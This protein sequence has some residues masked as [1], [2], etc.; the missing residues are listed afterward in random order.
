M[1]SWMLIVWI[2]EIPVLVCCSDTSQCIFKPQW[3]R[4]N[5]GNVVIAAFVPLFNYF[6]INKTI[7]FNVEKKYQAMFKVKNY[8]CTL[9]VIF[10]TEEI[11]RNPELL[12]NISLGFD[13]YNVQRSEWNILKEAFIWLTGM[14]INIPNYA[15]RRKNKAVAILTGTSWAISAR[16]GRLLSLYKYPQLSFG[17]F[18]SILS[19]QDQFSA[20]YQTASKDTSLSFGIVS[21]M[22]H[23]SWTWVGL[24]L[25]DNHKGTQILSDLRAEMYRNKVC[26]AF[27]KMMPENLIA[28][29]YASKET[30][31]WIMI[32]SAKVVI[33]YEDT[34]SLHTAMLNLMQLVI[35]W[36]VWV[37]NSQWDIAATHDYFLFDSLHGSLFF[38]H[39]HNEIADFR[40]FI[41][42]YNPSKYPDDHYLALLWSKFFNCSFSLQDCRILDNCLPNVSL[43]YLPTNIWEMDMTEEGYNI[44]NSVYAV[45]HSLHEMTLKQVQIQPHGNEQ[46]NFHP[47]ELHH[48]LKNIHFKNGAG[49]EV[50]MDP[51]NKLDEEYDILNFWNFPNGLR[52][53]LKVGTFSPKAPQGQQLFLADHMIQWAMGFKDVPHSVCSESCV[54]GFRKSP[55]E[56]QAA[57]CYDCTPCADNEISNET[58][59]DNCVKCPESHYAN[60]EKSHC[61]QKALKFLAYEDPLG[62][63][64]SCMTMGFF[65]LTTAV[66]GIFV[67]YHH[68]PIVKANNQALTYILLLTLTF[69][70]LCPLL[71]IGYPNTAICILQQ[72][73]YGVLFTVVLSTILAKTMT[74]VLAFKVTVPGKMMRWLMISKAPNFIILISTFIQLLLC[75]IWLYTSPPFVDLDAHSEHGYIIIVCNKGSVVAFHC[76]LG[77]LCS[78]ALG[79][80]AMAYLSRKLPDTFNEA[81]FLTFSMLVFLSVW[82]TFLPVYY[83]TKGRVMVTM[84]ILSIMA[85]SAGILGCIFAPKCH[86]I[87]L[88]PDRISLHYIRDKAHSRR[89]VHFTD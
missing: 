53:K 24:V 73:T 9:A 35:T 38:A 23:F 86:I 31:K 29:D 21:L 2:L 30:L 59:M 37:M 25:L 77:Y 66:L 61:L 69:C 32:S 12:P 19:D 20:L 56:G 42:T 84:E 50:V 36:K 33:V 43:E 17:P 13:L 22:L 65:V 74:V 48:F 11:N 68:T 27:V 87:L 71:F 62:M 51:Q 1:F 58:D 60:T 39:H 41:Q 26:V 70:F 34:E 45:A 78:L 8:Q 18:D 47:W 40:N 72:S 57:C 3:N 76:I 28:F 14:G 64:L 75:G 6:I 49:N 15:C 89:K 44:Y 88:R 54:S 52:Q 4:Y 16:I 81:R 82:V 85:S 5:D 80:Y 67:K 7:A 46:E 55:Q 83:S 63:V 10:A 79:S